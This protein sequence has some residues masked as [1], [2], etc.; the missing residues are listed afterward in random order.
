MQPTD[1]P[2]KTEAGGNAIKTRDR[3]LAPRQRTLLIMVDGV[4]PLQALSQVCSSFDEA[5]QM[6]EELHTA[7]FIEWVLQAAPL[8]PARPAKAAESGAAPAQAVDLRANIRRAT[9]ALEDLMGP[10]GLSFASQIEKCKTEDE[11][12]AKVHD[13]RRIVAVARS[14]KKAD[15]FVA[16]ALGQ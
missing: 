16:T 2:K 1:V 4:K 6:F 13:L 7:G 5:L 9:R 14:E 11:L 15:E 3:A 8:A 10:A 12:I